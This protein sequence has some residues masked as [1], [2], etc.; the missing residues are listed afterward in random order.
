ME[1]NMYSRRNF[2]KAAALGASGAFFP[3]AGRLAWAAG[4]S[5]FTRALDIPPVLDGEMDN[6]GVV[7]FDLLLR[8]GS[9]NFLGDR[10]TPTMGINGDYLGPVV[11][12]RTNARVR[13]NVHNTL[14]EASTL[15][16][17]GVHLPAKM[18][19]GPHQVI[20][21]GDSWS[22]EFRVRQPASTLWYH[23]HML[24][25]T[26]RQVYSGLAG[27]IYVEDEHSASLDLP[28]EYGVDDIP[29]VLQDRAFNADGSFFYDSSSG[30]GMRGMM[31]DVSLING[32][33]FPQLKVRHR[34]TRFRILNGSNARIYNLEFSDRRRFLQIAS[35]GGLLRR[36]V[37]LRRL[38]LAPGERAEIVVVFDWDDDVFLRDVSVPGEGMRPGGNNGNLGDIMHFDGTGVAGALVGPP[39]VELA[40]NI[41]SW[42]PRDAARRR[43]FV[44]GG[45][46]RRMGPGALTINGKYMDMNRIDETVRL[47]DIEAWEVIN[48]SPMAHPF[49]IHDVQFRIHARNGVTPPPSERSLKDTVLVEPGERV[50]LMMQF[51]DYSDPDSPYMYHCHILE[52]EDAGM[53]GQFVVS[54]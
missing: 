17:H 16:W 28:S 31:G 8:H 10:Q 50:L 33:A 20:A 6:D 13:M 44:L 34:R 14:D 30:P 51:R 43:R 41:P 54:S 29:L 40:E 37:P 21:A 48:R 46:R 47:G 25:E 18:D 42:K 3:L 32:V 5:R 9:R 1:K 26:G 23:S 36:R 4:E 45:G 12:L 15:H 7:N 35:D 19:G 2:L 39:P 27:L 38:R 24:H 22:P 49:H 11:R 52:H 53:M